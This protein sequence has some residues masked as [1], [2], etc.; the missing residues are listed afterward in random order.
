MMERL[1]KDDMTVETALQVVLDKC[2][3]TAKN[4]GPTDMVAAVLPVIVIQHA[5]KALERARKL[6]TI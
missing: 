5:R 2:D 1:L 4:C 6:A 3:Y